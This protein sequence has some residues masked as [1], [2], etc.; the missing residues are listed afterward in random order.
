MISASW[1]G[2]E[3][4]AAMQVRSIPLKP[5]RILVVSNLFPPHVVGGAELVAYRQARRLQ[6]RGHKVNVFAGWVAP[7]DQ[8]GRLT[9]EE[10]DGLRIWEDACR[11][12]RSR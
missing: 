8:A 10:E 4:D 9:V 1:E 7:A 2:P 3:L 6:A 5:W 11:F 12:V